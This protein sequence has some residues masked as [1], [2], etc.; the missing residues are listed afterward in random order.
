MLF[1][2]FNPVSMFRFRVDA[3][4]CISC[5]QCRRAC[6]MDIKVFENPNSMECIRCGACIEACPTK[7]IGAS[8]IMAGAC[9]KKNGAAVRGS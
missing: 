3:D 2:S 6:P 8:F 7:A 9:K 4:K 1:R 5:G